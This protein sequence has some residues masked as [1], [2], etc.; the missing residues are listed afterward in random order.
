MKRDSCEIRP[1]SF[2]ISEKSIIF[3]PEIKTNYFFN[4]KVE[5]LWDF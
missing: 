3:A 5:L 1:F 4:L 2:C